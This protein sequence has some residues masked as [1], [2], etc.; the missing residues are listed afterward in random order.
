M[1][2]VY[3]TLLFI[4]IL[5]ASLNISLAQ[6]SI[7]TR[8]FI[9]SSGDV[10]FTGTATQDIGIDGVT[11]SD[12]YVYGTTSNLTSKKEDLWTFSFFFWKF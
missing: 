5:T 12:G 7:N 9:D 1:K 6:S 2:F 8:I 3:F 10:T 4:I 11:F